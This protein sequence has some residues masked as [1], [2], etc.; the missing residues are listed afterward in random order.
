MLCMELQLHL[1]SNKLNGYPLLNVSAV[2][3]CIFL[4]SVRVLVHKGRHGSVVVSTSAW[5]AIVRGSIPGP[6]MLYRV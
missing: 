4:P 6:G 3:K 2:N 1:R 5:H